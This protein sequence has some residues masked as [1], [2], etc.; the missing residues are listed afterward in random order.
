MD[1]FDAYITL[2]TPVTSYFRCAKSA[3]LLNFRNSHGCI[4]YLTNEALAKGLCFGG[5]TMK[6]A[7]AA[8]SSE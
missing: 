1:I 7:D 2:W 4:P 6:E 3:E 5:S 8:A